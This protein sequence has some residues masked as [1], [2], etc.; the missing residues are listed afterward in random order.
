MRVWRALWDGVNIIEV[1]E[2]HIKVLFKIAS[3]YVYFCGTA[4]KRLFS[5]VFYFLFKATCFSLL[6][7]I[8]ILFMPELQ[9]SCCPSYW[10]FGRLSKICNWQI[11]EVSKQLYKTSTVSQFYFYD[12]IFTFKSVYF[13]FKP[14]EVIFLNC[15]T[16]YSILNFKFLLNFFLSK[17]CETIKWSIFIIF[18]CFSLL[19]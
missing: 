18:E 10:H 13:D 11:Q 17:N 12:Q 1:N 8:Y 19:E 2:S 16:Q 5:T 9:L 15:N 14:N 6:P 7:L 4:V 3:C